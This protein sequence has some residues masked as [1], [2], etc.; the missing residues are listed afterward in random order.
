MEQDKFN[1]I[2]MLVLFCLSLYLIIFYK[3]LL[4][5]WYET[6]N[7]DKYNDIEKY[8]Y[9]RAIDFKQKLGTIIIILCT[10]FFFLKAIKIF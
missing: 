6:F 7:I 4:K 3:Y 10:I 1:I 9:K 8:R 5:K 2:L